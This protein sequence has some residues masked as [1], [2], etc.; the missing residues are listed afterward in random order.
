MFA[1]AAIKSIALDRGYTFGVTSQLDNQFLKNDTDKKYGNTIISIFDTIK[2]EVV[3]HIP[4]GYTSYQEERNVISSVLSEVKNISDNIVMKGHY[5][6]PLYFMH[7]LEEVR[8]WFTLPQD[9]QL[10]SA[11]AYETI[12][13]KYPAGTVF[14]SVH[15][16]NAMDYRVKGFMLQKDYW[17]K[18]ADKMLLDK[19]S[20]VI[21]MVFYDKMTNIIQSFIK[22][23]K[24]EVQHNSLFVDFDM[25]SRCD[26]HIIC[27]SSYSLMS[28]LMD[29][30]GLNN[31]YC[32]S[33][34]P[35]PNGYYAT[36]TYPE[37]F[38]KVDCK[39]DRFSYF[40]GKVAPY[41]SPL[42]HLVVHNKK[43]V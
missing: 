9:I 22:K 5:I 13:E 18:A 29:K 17:Q 20:R 42:K 7:R 27:N 33:I 24:C 36:D 25:I 11:K 26:C 2:N 37:Q 31:T 19:G 39:R 30:K 38:I 8:Q 14:C 16:R 34:W 35:I 21:F 41:L 10:K 28:A 1:Y 40:L 4:Q 43:R 23:Y 15:F 12:K 3:D 32:P 6:A